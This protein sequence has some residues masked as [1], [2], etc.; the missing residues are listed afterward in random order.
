MPVSDDEDLPALASI[1]G[2]VRKLGITVDDL[3][4]G[5]AERGEHLLEE[6]SEL[7]RDVAGMTWVD[8]TTGTLTPVPRRIR[9]ICIASAFR[10]FNNPEGLT[11]RSIGDSSRSYDRSKREGGEAVYLTAAEEKSIQ[12]EAGGVAG[13]LVTATL[14]SG[15]DAGSLVDPWDAVTAE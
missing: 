13:G 15:Y 1:E 8:E 14:V 4:P 3:P 5:E 11:Q 6:A 2:L 10:A 7:I 12:K 9:M